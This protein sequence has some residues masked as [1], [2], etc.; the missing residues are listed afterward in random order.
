MKTPKVSAIVSTYKS[1]QFISG[2]LDDLLN[3]TIGDELE[4][5]VIDSGSPENEGEIVKAYQQKHSNIV[6]VRTERETVYAAW[7]RGIELARG[8]YLTNANTDDRR[9]SDMYEILSDYLDE[10]PEYDLVYSDCLITKE[11]NET[12]ERNSANGM[13][14]FMEHN[15]QLLLDG[16]C[17]VGPMPMWRKN[18]HEKVGL[19]DPNF[20]TS[21]DLEFWVRL[22]EVFN[23]KKFNQMLGLYMKRE[24]SI[25][26]SNL[27]AKALENKIISYKYAP[28]RATITK[29]WEFKKIKQRLESIQ[30]ATQLQQHNLFDQCIDLCN[31]LLEETPNEVDLMYLKATSYFRKQQFAAAVKLFEDILILDADHS[32]TLNNLAV[33]YWAEGDKKKAIQLMTR[34]CE[35]DE[36]NL[37]ARLNLADMYQKTGK[38]EK[39]ML[40]Y[41]SVLEINPLHKQAIQSLKE[42]FKKR[43]SVQYQ[44]YLDLEAR[45]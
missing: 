30:K 38:P 27:E 26:H 21:G 34:C 35:T 2:L 11:P 25:E 19:F 36:K 33:I 16:M 45:I 44:Y 18:V 4:I 1:E 7:N 39:A 23:L 13:Y 43:D 12:F 31:Q 14:K 10:H 17:Y 41:K 40:W 32:P 37:N 20:V 6:Y 22:S 15:R 24:D 29:S 5:I 28:S 9:K 8:T 3:Q 42:Y